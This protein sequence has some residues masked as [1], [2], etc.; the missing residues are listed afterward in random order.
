MT[1]ARNDFE[2]GMG[3]DETLHLVEDL[4]D[5]RNAG[6]NGGKSKEGALAEVLMLQLRGRD[7]I[8]ASG[9]VEQVPEHLPLVLQAGRGR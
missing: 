4:V 2:L 1:F 7:A 5:V 3:P 9:R 8:A 6:R